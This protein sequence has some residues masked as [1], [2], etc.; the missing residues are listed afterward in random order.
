M[1]VPTALFGLLAAAA[2]S[3]AA[4]PAAPVK[5]TVKAGDIGRVE[6]TPFKV[7]GKDPLAVGWRAAAAESALFADELTPRAGKTRLMVQGK[8]AGTYYLVLWSA[9]ETDSAVVEVEVTGAAPAPKP[10][11]D[12]DKPKP[13]PPAPSPVPIPVAGFRALIVYET[14]DLAKLPSAQRAVLTSAE[15]RGY[16]NDHCTP[17]PDGKTKEWRVLDKDADAGG[18]PALW[19]AALKRDRKSLPWLIV[20]DGKTGFEGPLPADTAATLALL[21]KYGGQ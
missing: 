6:I 2:L 21:R 10:A 8:K 1:R 17:G 9:G 7:E 20:S 11:P 16:L 19:Q 13:K 3:P 15:V 4:P 5:V 18:E 14:A 12:D